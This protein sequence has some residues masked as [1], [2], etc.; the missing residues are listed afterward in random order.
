[1][2]P[3]Q[4]S[5][6]C[7]DLATLRAHSESPGADRALAGHVAQC[8]RCRR[9]VDL[10]QREEA[11]IRA[12]LPVET[13]RGLLE[14]TLAA[15]DAESTPSRRRPASPRADRSTGAG[16]LALGAVAFAALALLVVLGRGPS[17]EHE[18]SDA[19]NLAATLAPQPSASPRA[20]SS[21][22]SPAAPETRPTAEPGPEPTPEALV[23]GPS[24]A[25][26]PVEP[27]PESPAATP[28][29]GST[30]APATA[31]SPGEVVAS[32]G[33]TLARVRSGKLAASRR[34][35]AAGDALPEGESLEV[36][37]SAAEVEGVDAVALVLA[38]HARVTVRAGGSGETVFALAAGSRALARTTG[39]GKWSVE[40]PD[41]RVTPLGTELVVAVEAKL[42][43]VSLLEG[44]ARVAVER[45]AALE[46]RAGFEAEV[47]RGHAPEA[48][49][50]FVAARA[51]AFLP[52]ALRPKKL[53]ASQR[54][55]RAHTFDDGLDGATKGEH[56]TTGGARGSRGCVRAARLGTD[57][58]VVV[59]M[60]AS[61]SRTGALVLD[62]GLWVE[63]TVK[64]DHRT[65]V[66]LQVWDSDAKENLAFYA[67][68]EPG[69]WTTVSAPLRSFGDAN[70]A[71]RSKPVRSG[72]RSTCFS[73]FAGEPSETVELLVDDVRFSLEE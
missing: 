60:D 8:A 51:V 46:V 62:P 16:W 70:G 67:T 71:P 27:A 59:E 15:L 63:V 33:K 57:Y 4:P 30:P 48:P 24:P 6:S 21:S 52:E 69:Q 53:P 42:T 11:A 32:R 7:P 56:V 72:D 34:T 64:V 14:K 58:A 47:A 45:A 29:P 49:R 9:L 1:M 50:P 55:V 68:V 41:A 43:R 13:P 37:G 20:P 26:P 66:V 31:P 5:S 19:P 10:A 40:T 25:G 18:G 2:S 39:A 35:F 28:G 54:L 17:S 61:A 22:P 73:V 3:T 44:R 23:P 12:A 38:A 36:Q 65:R